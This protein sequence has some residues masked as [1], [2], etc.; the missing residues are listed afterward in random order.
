MRKSHSFIHV[1][2]GVRHFRCNG[3]SKPRPRHR[4]MTASPVSVPGLLILFSMTVLLI[5]CAGSNDTARI[6]LS[7]PRKIVSAVRQV[8]SGAE[9]PDYAFMTIECTLFDGAEQQ[10]AYASRP[11][12]S[13]GNTVITFDDI[14]AGAAVTAQAVVYGA[15]SA[16]ENEP[17][18]RLYAGT[19]EKITVRPGVNTA[20]LVLKKINDTADVSI[21]GIESALLKMNDKT[22]TDI[23]E[24]ADSITTDRLPLTARISL[25]PESIQDTVSIRW[26]L[27]GVEQDGTKNPLSI[28]I[29]AF[30]SIQPGENVLISEIT[31]NNEVVT[32]E[33]SFMLSD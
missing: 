4:K 2:G 20:K 14:P 7:V 33:L 29:T 16:A 6:S 3:T 1:W 15:G 18:Y 9:T 5:S 13:D 22:G 31:Y 25:L 19:S 32:K 21:E 27:N 10:I 26:L 12:S 30:S 28:T 17:K 8:S 24:N 23:T 11:L